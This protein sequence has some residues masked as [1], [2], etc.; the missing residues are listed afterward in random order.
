MTI[1][2][3]VLPI[4][5]LVLVAGCDDSGTGDARLEQVWGKRGQI[6]GRFVKP[7]AAD[8]DAAG[9]LYVVDMR[10]TISVFTPQGRF[11]RQW[12]T[13]THA[14][15]R[16]SGLCVAPD[17]LVYVA[18]SHYHRILVYTPEGEIV[19]QY[20]GEPDLA[21]PGTPL[22]GEFG[23]IG[24]VAVD[25]N[26]DL[27][28]AEGHQRE[29]ITRIDHQGAVLARWGG[30]GPEPGQ[31]LRARSIVLGPDGLVWIADACNHRLQAFTKTGELR[32]V[33]GDA[34]SL[35]YPYDI[36]FAADGS[37]YVVEYGG[38]TVKHLDAGGHVIG[39]WGG[40]GRA[41]GKLNNPWALAVAPTGEVHVIDSVNDRVQRISF[42]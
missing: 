4:L 16:P 13:P 18:D 10:A 42:L 37:M 39:T 11:L 23:Y 30:K 26:G 19:R 36:D 31:F 17:G 6:P 9:N 8:T 34:E 20:G 25:T 5:A 12:Q 21:P 27:F 29:R 35:H 32:R 14:N 38:C 22:V 1:V 7:R 33:V 40:P 2:R 24:D 28:V 15:G 41:P 3:R